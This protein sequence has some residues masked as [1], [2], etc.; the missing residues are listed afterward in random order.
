M[1]TTFATILTICLLITLSGCSHSKT[2]DNTTP[3]QTTEAENTNFD[4][5]EIYNS[6]PVLQ[7]PLVFNANLLRDITRYKKLNEKD[8]H[9]LTDIGD[10]K[11]VYNNTAYLARLPQKDSLRFIIAS[12]KVP[13]GDEYVMELYSLSDKLQ[14]LDKL[15]LYSV[16]EVNGGKNKILQTFEVD[17]DYVIKVSKELES[18]LIEKLT[19]TPTPDG[20]FNEIRNGK[21]VT[22]AFDSYDHINY[23]IQTFVWNHNSNGGL[24]K[25]MLK[26]DRYKLTNNGKFIETSNNKA[27][28]EK[29]VLTVTPK[30]YTSVPENVTLHISNNATE[31]IQF[32]ANYGIEKRVGQSW[33]KQNMDDIAFISIMYSLDPGNSATYE[34]SLYPDR[35]KYDAGE[36][37]IHKNV[38][39]GETSEPFYAQFTIK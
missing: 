10:L 29:V 39:I 19:Y 26:T 34:I 18:V 25:K 38:L 36:Y 28:A 31:A 5:L 16:E 2:K 11:S 32:G 30:T 14:P 8:Y 20:V 27:T 13:G 23:Y 9:R 3:G 21:T 15:Q 33:V 6:L 24:R 35:I 12:Y 4:S 7:T 1:K 22:V 17:S 37:R